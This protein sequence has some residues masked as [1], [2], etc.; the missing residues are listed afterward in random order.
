MNG[1]YEYSRAADRF[2]FCQRVGNNTCLPHFH[3]NLEIVYVTEGEMK[4]TL[5]GRQTRVLANE[6]LLVPSYTVHQFQT[7]QHSDTLLLIVPLDYIPAFKSIFKKKTFAA[8]IYHD[9]E[10]KSELRHCL[11]LLSRGRHQP[12]SAVCRGY[13]QVIIGLLID[14]VGL[15]DIAEDQTGELIRDILTYLEENFRSPLDLAALA[16]HFGYSK[17]RF[18]HIFNA[19]FHCSITEYINTLRCRQAANLIIDGS[20]LLDAALQSGFENMRTFYRSFKLYFGATPTEYSAQMATLGKQ[21]PG[22]PQ[23]RVPLA[24]TGTDP[25]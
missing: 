10:A 2:P 1:T 3:G 20:P 15:C 23:Y 18:S 4:A 11:E 14:K 24:Q 13:I 17:S 16:Q 19:S 22:R 9:D 8:T 21:Q 12:D 7:D 25:A 5:N 6:A